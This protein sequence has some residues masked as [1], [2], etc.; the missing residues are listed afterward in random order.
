MRFYGQRHQYTCGVDLHARTMHVCVLDRNG[1]VVHDQ[2]L[3]A[4]AEA[5]IAAIAPFREDLVVAVEC[6][7]AW[8]WL[9]D[10]CHAHDIAFV[11]GHA[12]YMKAIHGGKKKND[13]IDAEK[14][15]RLT[16][17]GNLPTAYVYPAK[18][19]ATRDLMRRR[20]LF[21]RQRAQ[22]QAH[23]RMT[24][25]QYNLPALSRSITAKAN[26]QGVLKHFAEQDSAVL[27]TIQADLTMIDHLNEQIHA[28]ER[29]IMRHARSHNAIIFHLLCTI[30]GVGKVLALTML[31][32][33]HQIDRFERVQDLLSYCRLVKPRKESA[34]KSS[35]GASG[36]K[37][38]NAHLKW[39]FSEAAVLMMRNSE[40]AKKF[41]ERKA[42][43]HGKAK[44]ISLLAAKLG[45]AVYHML[46]DRQPFDVQRFFN[47]Q[48]VT[49]AGQ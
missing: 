3:P 11:L 34:G 21:V 43:R 37:I 4:Q 19:R 38:G 18:M 35:G 33:I 48:A 6:M 23:I 22:L 7:F 15:A 41:V 31:Y 47:S 1:Q 2:N 16:Y 12:L 30:P 26:R 32:E 36:G 24:G 14:I 13:Q 25:Q 40:A 29:T 5:F 28:L 45:R 8:Y 20:T 10:L 46:R 17:G 42:R 9:A 49:V 27:A 44:A 39:A